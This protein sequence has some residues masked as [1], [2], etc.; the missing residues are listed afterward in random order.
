MHLTV[1]YA[2]GQTI[3]AL[4]IGHSPCDDPAIS[5]SDKFK[6]QKKGKNQ[7]EI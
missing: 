5:K 6:F 7:Q 3:H 2:P 4:L 1:S